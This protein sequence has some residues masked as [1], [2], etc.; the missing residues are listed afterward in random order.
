MAD[1]SVSIAGVHLASP[2]VLAAGTAGYVREMA[3]AIDLSTIGAVT[4]KSI[5]AEPREGNPPW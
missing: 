1:L 4:T 3:D 2:I 5:T